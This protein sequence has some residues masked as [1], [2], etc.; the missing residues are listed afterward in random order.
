MLRRRN[1]LGGCVTQLLTM[2]RKKEL[3]KLERLQQAG[4]VCS[5]EFWKLKGKLAPKTGRENAHSITK[6]DKEIAWPGEI[7]E[8]FFEHYLDV[9]RTNIVEKGYEFAQDVINRGALQGM[10]RKC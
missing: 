8:A 10:C 9:L 4:G 1:K 3:G 6:E 2:K 5:D 7:K